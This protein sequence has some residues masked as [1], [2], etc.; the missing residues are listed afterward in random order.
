[1]EDRRFVAVYGREGRTVGAIGFSLPRRLMQFRQAIAD[2]AP[3]PP[4]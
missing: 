1:V 3:F 2:R 4:G